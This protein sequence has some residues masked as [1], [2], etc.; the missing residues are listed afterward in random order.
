MV[1]RRSVAQWT[2]SVDSASVEFWQSGIWHQ[3][4]VAAGFMVSDSLLAGAVDEDDPRTVGS[5]PSRAVVIAHRSGIHQ[6]AQFIW[7][8][9]VTDA[10]GSRAELSL[11]CAA[12]SLLVG[13]SSGVS[14]TRGRR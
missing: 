10:G 3:P 2:I 9:L 12:G 6:R 7:Q 11:S 8:H 14:A 1:R 13:A 5:R 4:R